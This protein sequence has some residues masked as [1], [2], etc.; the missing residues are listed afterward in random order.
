MG[1]PAGFRSSLAFALAAA[2]IWPS[3]VIAQSPP[4]KKLIEFGWDEP[5]PAFLRKHIAVMECTPFDG[6]V[7]HATS[8]FLWKGWSKRAFKDDELAAAVEDL[9]AVKPSRFTHN[10]LRFNVTPGDVDWFDDFTPILNNARLAAKIAKAGRAAG[11]LFDIEQYNSQLFHYPKQSAA[12]TKTWEEYSNQTKRRGREVM[13]AFQQEF[14]DLVVFMTWS[15]SLPFRQSGGD[16]KK[17]PQTEY[18]L[19][20]PFLDGMFEAAAG[21]TKIVDGFESSYGFKSPAQFDAVPIAMKKTVLP[22]MADREKYL[23]HGS[24][25]FGLWMDYDWRKKAWDEKDFAKN[26]FSPPEFEASVKAAF[27][28]SDEYV[29]IYTEKPRWWTSPDGKPAALPVEYDRALRR[30]VGRE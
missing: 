5:N 29:W 26:H 19:L 18:G 12:K 22:W 23:R 24:L 9:K 11:I 2:L 8:D 10:L 13:T 20:K 25:G 27:A 7:F 17:L 15:Y 6:T 28:A 4:R 21:Q 16:E 30:A 1:T 3:V 14:P